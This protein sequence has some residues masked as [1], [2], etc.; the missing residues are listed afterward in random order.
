MKLAVWSERPAWAASWLSDRR[1]RIRSRRS[2]RAS[3]E[4]MRLRNGSIRTLD[5]Y[6]SARPVIDATSSLSDLRTRIKN[7]ALRFDLAHFDFRRRCF[8]GL[9]SPFLIE[10]E[11]S[12]TGS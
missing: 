11:L 1:R 10:N 5:D 2:S 3:S 7:D 4:Q 9:K 12:P 8:D 6:Q